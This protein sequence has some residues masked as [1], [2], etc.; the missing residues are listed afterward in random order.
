MS[1]RALATHLFT[2]LFLAVWSLAAWFS[3]AYQMP[4]PWAVLQGAWKFL[5]N[6]NLLLQLGASLYHVAAA[7]F[8]SFI[9]GCVLA[10][11]P[12]YFPV[13]RTAIHR[14]F[15]AFLG[16]FP[17]VGWALLAGMWFGINS[18]SVIFAISAVLLPFALVNLN[19]GLNNLDAELM[20]MGLSFT[21]SRARTLRRVI[22]PLLYPY[23]FA[24]LRL[25]F[26]VAWKVTLAAELFGGNSGLGYL[27]NLA[28]QDYDTV[29]IFVIIFFIIVFVYCAERFFFKPIQARFDA[30]AKI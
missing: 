8:L 19:S 3:P 30:Y 2:L 25:M 26:G 7:I 21:R 24:T 11:I 4:G 13:S 29:T 14:R 17:G 18:I 28:R 15:G 20:E 5:E 16:S 22:L 10:L 6:P 1:R 23:L 12:Y 27:I 9:L